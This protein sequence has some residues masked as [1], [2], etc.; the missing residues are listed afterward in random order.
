MLVNVN[1]IEAENAARNVVLKKKTMTYD[2]YEEMDVEGVR[3][4]HVHTYMHVSHSFVPQ[5]HV[6]TCVYVYTCVFTCIC[7]R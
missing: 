5:L 4:A 7:C 6:F 2:P 1:L 3:N